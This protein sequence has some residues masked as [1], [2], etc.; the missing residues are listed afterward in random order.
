MGRGRSFSGWREGRGRGELG[1]GGG[2]VGCPSASLYRALI[3]RRHRMAWPGP[4]ILC[5]HTSTP[6][7]LTGLVCSTL[8][9]ASDITEVLC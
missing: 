9:A 8:P 5:L 4:E 3:T 1:L 7:M 2:M 6:E